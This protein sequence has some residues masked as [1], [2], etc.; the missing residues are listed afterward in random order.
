M[1][2]QEQSVMSRRQEFIRLARTETIPFRQRCQRF[3]ISHATGYTLLQRV[4]QDGAAGL[5]DRS[6]RPGT[7]PRQTPP[8]MAAAVVAVRG[9]TAFEAWLIRL[10]LAVSHGAFYHPQTQGKVE[11]GH[12]TIGAD[13]FTSRS[14]FA[15]LDEVQRAFDAFRHTYNVERPHGALDHA[16]PAS[17]YVPS[18]RP[19]PEQLPDLV[20]APDDHVLKVRAQGAVWFRG[21]SRFVSRGLI[22]HY[23]GI[24]PT[25]IDGVFEIRYGHCSLLTFDLREQA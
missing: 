7:S 24:R 3:G 1:P 13:V 5:V 10:G 19:F 15:T 25:L 17:R 12:R 4:A 2:W 14:P 20:Y 16:V 9:L 8:A 18:P 21:R 22:G 6:R 23:V 11:R